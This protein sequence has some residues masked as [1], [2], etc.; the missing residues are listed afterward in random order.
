LEPAPSA[1][2]E[3]GPDSTAAGVFAAGVGASVGR[4]GASFVYAQRYDAYADLGRV[5]DYEIVG[6]GAPFYRDRWAVFC[7]AGLGLSR[8]PV[9]RA[10]SFDDGAA[11]DWTP[12]VGA[13]LGYMPGGWLEVSTA[14]TYRERPQVVHFVYSEYGS[15]RSP[16]VD[17][18]ANCF[19]T[20]APFIALGPSFRHILYGPYDFYLHSQTNQNKGWVT[21]QETYILATVAVPINF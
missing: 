6:R 7:L 14:V 17:L 5:N 1:Y 9:A 15:V 12:I 11:T 19:L 20:P 10:F 16:A 2:S 18:C 8:S 3:R 13:G 21:G 4:W